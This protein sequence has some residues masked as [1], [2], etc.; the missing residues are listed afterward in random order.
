MITGRLMGKPFWPSWA[1]SGPPVG[2]MLKNAIC[3]F[4]EI[5]GNKLLTQLHGLWVSEAELS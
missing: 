1:G 4:G 3:T 5:T 2:F